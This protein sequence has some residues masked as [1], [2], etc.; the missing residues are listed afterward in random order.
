MVL[1]TFSETSLISITALDGTAMN[2]SAIIE[3]IDISDGEKGYDSIATISG[4]RLK[5]FNPQEDVEVTIEGYAVEAGTDSGATGLG[6]YDLQNSQDTSQPISISVDR[7]RTE[8]QLAVMCTDNAAQTTAVATT[9]S[10]D[11]AMRWTFENGH[12][13]KVDASFTDKVWKFSITFKCPPF[14]KSGTA[15]YTYESTDGTADKVLP[16]VTYTS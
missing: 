2:F 5:K 6:F 15:N 16:A 4:G 13:T 11:K 10:T 7:V 1:D 9:T 8:Y 14:N 12:F 3:T